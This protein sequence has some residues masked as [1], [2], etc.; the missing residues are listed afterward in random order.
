VIVNF[1][2]GE[3]LIRCLASVVPSLPF[4]AELIVVDNASSDGSADKASALFPGLK[5]VRSTTNDGFGAGAN[6]G[7]TR[8]RGDCLIF[9]NP[10]T[11]VEPGWVEGLLTL[12]ARDPQAGLATSKILQLDTGRVSGCGNAIHIT[13][14]TLAR[15][16][17]ASPEAFREVEPVD[18]VSGA[19]F[20]VRRDLFEELGGFDEDF[21]LYVEDTDLS[22]RARLA[23]WRCLFAPES[24]V[25]HDYTFRL[26]AR[27]V[28][29]QERNR[30]LMLLKCLRW[31]TLLVLLPSELLAELVTWGF[32]L[33]RDRANAG[34]K[35]RA[36][37]WILSHWRSILRKRRASQ[38]LRRI[39]DRELLASTGF[40]LDFGQVSSGFLATAA[41]SVFDPLFFLLRGATRGLV[42]W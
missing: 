4:G 27:K 11:L 29:Y 9:L 19:S 1:N 7:A 38:S 24:V 40:R 16:M 8:A 12:L 26:T 30:Y 20:A 32:V 41:R 13:G 31:P 5:I 10:D 15:G 23:G 17:G 28:F 35:L 21:F 14:L 34:N 39:S 18:A 42:W 2:G 3:K 36:Y 37:G 33:L 22:M 6:L 25:Y